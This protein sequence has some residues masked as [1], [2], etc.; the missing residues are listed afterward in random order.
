M[1]TT[2]TLSD[3]VYDDVRVRAAQQG[4]SVSSVI[5][6]AVRVYL[7]DA[8]APAPVTAPHLPM[9]RSGGARPGIDLDDFSTGRE[10]VDVHEPL[11]A[12][13]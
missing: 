3:P 5:E 8:A 10:F 7:L 1:R 6:E 12:V 11:D 4:R 9:W 2:V 13:R